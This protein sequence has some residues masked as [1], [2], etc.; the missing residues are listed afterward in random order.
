MRKR[1]ESEYATRRKNIR[2]SDLKL[3]DLL[4]TGDA[5]RFVYQKTTYDA[6]ITRESYLCAATS[7]SDECAFKCVDGRSFYRSPTNFT[8]D[9]VAHYL[10]EKKPDSENECHTNPSG[11]ERIRHVRT[12]RSLNEVR[13]EY[14]R[15]YIDTQN[16]DDPDELAN[17]VSLKS[18]AAKRR[19]LSRSSAAQSSNASVPRDARDLGVYAA[20][21]LSDR[22]VTVGTLT[23]KNRSRKYKQICEVLE[24]KVAESHCLNR[25]LID[26][27][28]NFLLHPNRANHLAAQQ[29]TSSYRTQLTVVDDEPPSEKEELNAA[30]SEEDNNYLQHLVSRSPSNIDSI[31]GD[32]LAGG[33]SAQ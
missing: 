5:L 9:C 31:L 10:H 19:R 18:R 23:A 6:S 21:L 25:V 26:T 12:D 1:V 16:V 17:V 30:S 29:L 3:V 8:L 13:D 33:D 14:M 11:W 2:L 20:Q 22:D 24:V 27:L 32:A 15:S 28:D 7:P 4:H